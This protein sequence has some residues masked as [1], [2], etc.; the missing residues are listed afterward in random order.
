MNE[1]LPLVAV[2]LPPHLDISLLLGSGLLVELLGIVAG[3]VG[4]ASGIEGCKRQHAVAHFVI[5]LFTVYQ[6]KRKKAAKLSF[7]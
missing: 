2:H 6:M 4:A 5:G 1:S 7:S 3:I